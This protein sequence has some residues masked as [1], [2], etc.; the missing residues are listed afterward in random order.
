MVAKAAALPADEVI[1]DLEDAVAS[2]GKAQARADLVGLVEALDFGSRTLAVRVNRVGTPEILRDL[3]ELVRRIG[4]RLDCVV[5]PKVGSVAEVGFVDC[6]LA[7]LEA[8]AGLGRRIGIELQ[9]EDPAGLEAASDLAASSTRL[10]ALIFGPGDFAAAMGM[11]QLTIGG[12]GQD[13]PGDIWQYPL[14]RIAVAARARG[15][16]VIDGPYS[17]ITDQDGLERACRRGAA[18]GLDGKWAIHP[19][20]LEAVNRVFTPSAAQ[21]ERATA[22]LQRVR[23]EGGASGFEGGMVDEATRRMAEAIVSRGARRGGAG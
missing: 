23:A 7:S 13:Y 6:C 11:P 9:I 20:Q 15:L 8:E 17:Q 16:Q 22:V 10:E 12:E 18:L 3:L 5:V 19:A 14:Y 4:A 1:L 21:L 2:G